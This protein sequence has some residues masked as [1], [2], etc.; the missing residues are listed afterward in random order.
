MRATYSIIINGSQ[1]PVLQSTEQGLV[2]L[3]PLVLLIPG[4][5]HL[6]KEGDDNLYIKDVLDIHNALSKQNISRL[7]L[8]KDVETNEFKEPHIK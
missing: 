7:R 8:H 6:E 3:N 1:V 2:I 5:V 4:H